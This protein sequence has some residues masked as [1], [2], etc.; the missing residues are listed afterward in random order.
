MMNTIGMLSKRED[1]V[2]ERGDCGLGAGTE[3]MRKA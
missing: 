1:G 3:I 2:A